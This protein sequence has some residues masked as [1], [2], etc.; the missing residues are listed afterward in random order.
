MECKTSR[1]FFCAD[2]EVSD[3]IEPVTDEK[4]VSRTNRPT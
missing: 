1:D 3:T 4:R 2:G